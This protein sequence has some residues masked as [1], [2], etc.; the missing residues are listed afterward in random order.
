MTRTDAIIKLIQ[1]VKDSPETHHE[2]ASLSGNL[3]NDIRDLCS[4]AIEK[5]EASQNEEGYF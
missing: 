3:I 5:L 2:L 4:E 1:A